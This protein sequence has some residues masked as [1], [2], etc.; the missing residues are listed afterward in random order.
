M[1]KEKPLLLKL[2]LKKK[3]KRDIQEEKKELSKKKNM[4]RKLLE[5]HLMISWKQKQLL[6]VKSKP[7]KLKEWKEQRSKLIHLPKIKLKQRFKINILNNPLLK[8]QMQALST[9]VS[10]PKSMMFQEKETTEEVEEEEE[11][12]EVAKKEEMPKLLKEEEESQ[13]PNS[14]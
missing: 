2:E 4:L 14:L 13:M 8:L 9:L 10:K 11:E 12:E 3:K 5:S 6:Q 1:L 7:E